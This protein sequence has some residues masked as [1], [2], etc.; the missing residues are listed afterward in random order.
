MT[1]MYIAVG[2]GACQLEA[3]RL[4]DWDTKPIHVLVSYAYI[5][6]WKSTKPYF[7]KPAKLMLDSGAFTAYTSGKTVDIQALAQEA[8]K[9][10]WDEAVGLDVI[11]SWQGSKVNMDRMLAMGCGKAMPVFHVGDP[12]DLLDYY[13]SKWPKIGL[14]CRFGEDIKTSMKFYEQ[15][16]A[17]AWPKKF[18]SFGWTQHEPLSAFPFHSADSSSWGNA[19]AWGNYMVKKGG[20]RYGAEHMTVKGRDNWTKGVTNA[21]EINH[22]RERELVDR[23]GKTLAKLEAP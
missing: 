1:A 17:R 16:F 13:A 9:P 11:G 23:W 2:W 18:H 5:K 10:E 7:R 19:A 4:W 8:L 3:I 15:C 22:R 12:W 20:G 14:S 6:N 21:L